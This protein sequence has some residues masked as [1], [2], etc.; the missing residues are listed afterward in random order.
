MAKIGYGRVS[1]RDQNPDSQRDALVEAGCDKIFIDK[2]SGKLASRPE[3][4]KALDYA[5]AGDTF[6]VTRLARAAR[7]LKH[8]IELA[9]TLRERG[10][11]L[12]VLKQG[13]DT[14][15]PTGR[16]AF[17]MLGA[18]DEFQRELIV[19]GT[20]EGLASARARGRTGGRR[21]TLTATQVRMARQMYDSEEYTVQDIADSF[22]TSRAT[23][24]RALSDDSDFAYV[25]YRS[26]KPKAR[27]DGT[28]MGE[29][30]QGEQSTAQYDADRQFF[31]L[32][33]HKRPYAKAMVYVVDGTVKRI[34]AIA[35]KGAWVPHG[36]DWEIPVTAPL[37]PS[38]I[39]EQ[40]PTL[41]FTLGDELPAQRGKLRQH[42]AL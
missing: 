9:E 37:T 23:V 14:S 19:E 2:A 11:D 35:P 32:A 26:G 25:V 21:P 36:G 28:P 3:L 4:D 8:L 27:A 1:T 41:G 20:H 13:I 30:G 15:T 31:P 10:I 40:F 6:V 18:I 22:H 29:T 39:A 17:H 12:V 33:E 34:R 24:Y 7:S 5:R 38:E 16:L 42:L